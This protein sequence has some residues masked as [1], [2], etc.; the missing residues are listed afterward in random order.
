[1]FPSEIVLIR[2]QQEESTVRFLGLW[3]SDTLTYSCHIN[4]LK[5]KLNSGLYFLASSKNNSPLRIMINMYHAVF[6]SHLRFACEIYGSATEKLLDEL[7]ILQKRAIRII[8]NSHYLSH[9]DPIFLKL[10]LLKLQDL[11]IYTRVCLVHKFR[12]GLLPRSF[13]RNYFQYIS[14][15]ESTRRGDPLSLKVPKPFN[16]NLLRS[17]Y[18]LIC[19]DW[20]NL[21]YEIKIIPKHN[22][23]KKTVHSYLTSKYTEPCSKL[24][25]KSCPQNK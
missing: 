23:F 21:P 1:M 2:H 12:L 25:C 19:Q 24:D 9:T 7:F 11:F 16:K 8:N 15:E 13:T 14:Q 20:N 3:V 5:P 10:K 18:I 4:K 6:E 17:P 22:E